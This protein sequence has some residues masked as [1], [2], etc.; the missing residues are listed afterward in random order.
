MY[1]F[2]IYL[3]HELKIKLLNMLKIQKHKIQFL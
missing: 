3:K 1:V 2:T